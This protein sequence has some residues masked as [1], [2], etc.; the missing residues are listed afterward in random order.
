MRV[1]E[2]DFD[3]PPERIALRPVSPRDAAR[4]LV[5]DGARLEDR[6]VRD[7]PALLRPGDL[8]IANDTRVIP[9]RLAG[10]RGEVRIEATLHKRLD[11]S[12][13]AAFA[14]PGKRLHVGDRVEFVELTATVEAKSDGGEVTLAFDRAGE[15]LDRA[16]EAGGVPPLP[17]YIAS[18]RPVDAQDRADYQT[19]HAE[20]SGSVAAPTAGL[21]FTP[22]LWH[23]LDARGI[24]HRFVTLH[25]GAGTFLPVK[26]DD[27][28]DH[29]MHAEQG[30]LDA[31]TAAAIAEAKAKGGRVVAIGTTSLRVLE[32]S[33]GAAFHGDIDLFITPGYRFK[34]VDLM[35]TNFHLPRSTLFML[36]A[37]FI[38]LDRARAA[39]TH[40]IANGYRFYSYGDACLL[41]R[42]AA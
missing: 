13:W 21:H 37:A 35:M 20:A 5:V 19:L 30:T 27:T 12:R 24:A 26:S 14:R 22:E 2:F 16:I 10:R 34:V 17:P 9:A 11:A 32:A 23:A 31:A 41:T 18:R 33:G 15:A 28:A 4:L 1:A 39:Y 25:V 29:R 40:A 36:V 7:L 38:G 3:L 42:A 6:I 8:V